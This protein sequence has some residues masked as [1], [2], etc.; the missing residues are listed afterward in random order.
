MRA[1]RR[2]DVV[3]GVEQHGV[4]AVFPRALET[5]SHSIVGMLFEALKGEWRASNVAARDSMTAALETQA[6]RD[7]PMI[8]REGI[9]RFRRNTRERKLGVT[10]RSSSSTTISKFGWS[11]PRK[12]PPLVRLRSRKGPRRLGDGSEREVR[13]DGVIRGRFLSLQEQAPMPMVELDPRWSRVLL[14]NAEHDEAQMSSLSAVWPKPDV[15][16][17]RVD[18][19]DAG[20]GSTL[21]YRRSSRNA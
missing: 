10:R 8:S 20:P 2:P 4:S 6:P 3:E 13:R 15:L 5:H 7:G 1:H 17:S 9:G 12:G 18:V 21:R 14:G 19:R 16:G 11:V